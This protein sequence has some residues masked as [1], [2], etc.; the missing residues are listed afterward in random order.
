MRRRRRTTESH[1]FDP[2]RNTGKLPLR[3]VA[4]SA[5]SA[6][7]VL[8]GCIRSHP[9][10]LYLMDANRPPGAETAERLPEIDSELL[11]GIGPVY[12]PEYLDRTEIVRRVEPNELELA[13][14]H[15]WA[16]PL[17]ASVSNVVSRDV[18]A[19]LGSARVVGFP[20]AAAVVP[21]VLVRIDVRQFDADREGNV[22][23][24]ADIT[25]T[26]L[27]NRQASVRHYRADVESQ[28]RSFADIAGTHRRALAE[29]S[30]DIARDL[31]RRMKDSR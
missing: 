20:W 28:G 11:I 6:L 22:T 23:L 2:R 15:Q 21:D 18:R 5:M 16:Q 25:V 14:F 19:L 17:D 7:L 4:M 1:P 24:E 27:D 30:A 13:E 31:S 26:G 10:R 8:T 3:H 12:V 9:N 29:M